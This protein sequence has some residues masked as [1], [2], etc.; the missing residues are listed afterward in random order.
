MKRIGPSGVSTATISR[1][2]H[3]RSSSAYRNPMVVVSRNTTSASAGADVQ[4]SHTM[5]SS[6]PGRFFFICTGT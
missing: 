1:R 3:S 5:V 2:R 4:A 6:V